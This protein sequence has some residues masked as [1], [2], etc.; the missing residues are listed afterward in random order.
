MKDAWQVCQSV[1]QTSW[2]LWSADCGGMFGGGLQQG[3][4]FLTTYNF[5]AWMTSAPY[6]L[7]S[8]EFGLASLTG[9]TVSG[10]YMLY[11]T[12]ALQPPGTQTTNVLYSFNTVSLAWATVATSPSQTF[13][14]AVT[15]SPFSPLMNPT[16]SPSPS[17]TLP[18]TAVYP[19][20]T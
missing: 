10:T 13:W 17:V 16:F 14:R 2:K 5:G 1:W 9:T 3:G 6:F 15:I 4:L 11:A 12:A 19:V 20:S 8:G 7:P 18:F